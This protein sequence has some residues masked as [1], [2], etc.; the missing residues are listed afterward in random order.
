MNIANPGTASRVVLRAVTP[1]C[2]R[3]ITIRA[4]VELTGRTIRE[5]DTLSA[6]S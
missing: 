2:A 5:Y 3:N 4:N 1:Q 6:R